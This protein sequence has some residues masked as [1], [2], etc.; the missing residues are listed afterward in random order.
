M[1][2]SKSAL[3]AHLIT[4]FY[5]EHGVRLLLTFI[6]ISAFI[7]IQIQAA[8]LGLEHTCTEKTTIVYTNYTHTIQKKIKTILIAAV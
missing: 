2:A 3:L 6:N 4:E 7:P 1:I 8:Q 5:L